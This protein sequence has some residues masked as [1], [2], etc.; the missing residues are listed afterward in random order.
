MRRCVLQLLSY[1]GPSGLGDR[2]HD[3]L[4]RT[5]SWYKDVQPSEITQGEN[6][7]NVFAFH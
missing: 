6:Q 3:L 2:P 1:T 5:A 4:P 7:T